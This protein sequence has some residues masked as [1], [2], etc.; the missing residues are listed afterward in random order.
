[1]SILL[2]IVSAG[3]VQLS[4]GYVEN[5]SFASPVISSI[6]FGSNGLITDLT[7][8]DP[9]WYGTA[10]VTAIGADYEI[11]VT[12]TSG[13]LPAGAMDTWTSLATDQAWSVTQTTVGEKETTLLVKIRNLSGNV[14]AENTFILIAEVQSD[15]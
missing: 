6:S 4:G 15:V 1:M 14:M 9:K 10:P 2:S 13:P 5:R 7:E 12:R 11:F 8:G 3:A